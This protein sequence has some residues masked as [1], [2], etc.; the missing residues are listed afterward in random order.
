MRALKAQLLAAVT[1]LAVLLSSGPFART[2]FFCT[3]M[4]RVVAK[5]CCAAGSESEADSDATL[6]IRSTD[7]CSKVSAA[8]RVPALQAA[9]TEVTVAP[10]AIVATISDSVYELPRA[11]PVSTLPR[12]ARAPPIVGPPLFIA[13]CSLL[14]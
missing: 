13:H 8:K 9:G 5:C 4:N 3:M 11:A 2:Q 14:T 1:A 6:Q 10:A 7:C 12:Q